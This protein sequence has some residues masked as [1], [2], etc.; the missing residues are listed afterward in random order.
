MDAVDDENEQIA[1]LRS[2]V[3]G[4]L[5]EECSNA[6]LRNEE[7]IMEGSFQGALID[8]MSELVGKAYRQCQEI[9]LKKIYKSNVVM[10]IEIAGY[11]IIHTLID[12]VVNAVFNPD[13]A[14]SRQLI[15]RIPEQYET[16][17]EDPYRKIMAVL[18]Y[19]SGMTDIYA[20][21]LYR[22]IN[23]MSLPSL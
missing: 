23:G 22:K 19:L 15:N 5:V 8:D 21:D 17:N 20:L 18:D 12:K 2:S 14:Y 16:E 11:N 6:F 10:D 13:K 1:Y 4:V 3:I 9:S 7:A